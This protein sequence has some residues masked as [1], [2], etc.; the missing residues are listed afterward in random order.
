MSIKSRKMFIV[1]IAAV[2][3]IG[4]AAAGAGVYWSINTKVEKT[5]NDQAV[6]P[7]KS[8]E[9]DGKSYNSFVNPTAEGHVKHMHYFLFNLTNGLSV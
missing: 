3:L 2:S 8:F 4:I 7:K 1:I 5:T 6:Q 9:G